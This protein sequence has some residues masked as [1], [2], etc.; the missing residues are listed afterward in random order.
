MKCDWKLSCFDK[1]KAYGPL[2]LRLALGIA[3]I[4]H[5]YAKLVDMPGTIGAFTSMGF[6]GGAMLAAWVTALAEFLGGIGVLVGFL[7]RA[8]AVSV[9]ML[10]ALLKVKLSMGYLGGYELDLAYLSMALSLLL[11]GPSK[12]S[13]EQDM[14]KKK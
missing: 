11:M 13:V 9:V 5:G 2:L 4:V 1:Y 14:M 3:F 12:V 8:S 7:T 6:G 10:V